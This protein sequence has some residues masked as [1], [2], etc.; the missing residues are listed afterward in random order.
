MLILEY[1]LRASKAQQSAIDEAIRTVQFI[2]NKAV[3][4]WM[5]TRGVGQYDLQA[6]CA[7]LAQEYPFAARL[8]SMARQA[9]ADRAWQSIARFYQNCREKKPGKKGYPRFQKDNRSVEYKTSG[10]K[11]E[12][13]GK[14]LTFTDGIGIGTLRLI[15]TRSIETFPISQIKRVR[16]VKR[17]DGY[18][19][20]FAVQAERKIDHVPTGKQ[21]GIDVGLRAYYTDSQGHT[22]A[23]PRYLR[24][25]EKRLKRLHRRKDRKPKGSKNRRKAIKRLAKGYLKVSR[26]RKDFAAKTASALVSSHDLIAYEDLKVSNLV[27]NRHLA[28]SISDAGWYGFL[29][30][31]RYYGLLHGIPIVAVPARFTTQ[32]CSECGYRVKKTLSMRTHG[33]PSCGLVLDRDW[34]AALNI[35]TAALVIVAAHHRTAGQ[36]ETGR[37]SERRNASGQGTSGTRKRLRSVKLAG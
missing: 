16:L 31:V 25:A 9:S 26:Q 22:V 2:R 1:K 28:K 20:Q 13:D 18:Y 7:Q 12:P 35:L 4:A 8:N 10:W 5:D 27:K 14:R 15:G 6:L 32:D 3:R 21:V 30:W 34:N 29:C 23:N 19:C 37:S 36:A 24:K 33:C 11:L 17:A